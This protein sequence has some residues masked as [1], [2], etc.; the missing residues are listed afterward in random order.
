MTAEHNVADAFRV[1]AM[2]LE[3]KIERGR[4]TQIDANDLLETLLSIADRLD[5]PVAQD[6]PIEM[7]EP[8]Y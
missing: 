3:E 8:P 6:E 5:P 2:R 4:S 1:V 7:V